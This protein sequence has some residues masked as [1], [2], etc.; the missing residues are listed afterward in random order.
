M[1]HLC[2]SGN[3]KCLFDNVIKTTEHWKERLAFEG[4]FGPREAKCDKYPLVSRDRTILSPFHIKLEPQKK[5][6]TNMETVSNTWQDCLQNW[7]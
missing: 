2:G 3:W 6:L 5:L 4:T 1:D 7:H